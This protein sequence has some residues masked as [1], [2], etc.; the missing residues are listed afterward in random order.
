MNRHDYFARFREPSTWAAI[1]ALL[2]FFG[3]AYTG[4]DFTDSVVT[5]GVAMTGALGVLLGEKR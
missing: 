4:P 2:S 3:P 1:A 5:L